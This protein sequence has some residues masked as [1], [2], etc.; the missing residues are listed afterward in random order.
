MALTL[1]SIILMIKNQKKLNTWYDYIILQR[2]TIIF[3]KLN[4]EK[5]HSLWLLKKKLQ[6]AKEKEKLE[7][8]ILR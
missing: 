1:N 2:F 4:R 5:M 6:I 3:C 8:K 7:L